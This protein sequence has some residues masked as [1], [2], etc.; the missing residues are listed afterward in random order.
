MKSLIRMFAA[1]SKAVIFYENAAT[2]HRRRH[3]G[4]T[5]I[6]LPEEL[7]DVAPA[8]FREAILAADAEWTQHPKIIDTLKRA[9]TDGL[10]RSAFRKTLAKEM[11][12][13]HV[14]FGIDGG[15]GHIVEDEDRWPRGDLFARELLGGMLDA[16]FPVIKKQ[17]SWK[18]G[19]DR[20]VDVFKQ[21]WDQWD[22][23]KVLT[24]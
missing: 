21:V 10:G 20:R 6:P 24:G 17:G 23:T 13:F 12:Y 15:L 5:A 2:P 14:W 4:I 1:Q 7:G 8:Y 11:P 19:K 3:A 22:W 16:D 9:R 18:G